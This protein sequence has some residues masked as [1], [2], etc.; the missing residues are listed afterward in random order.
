MYYLFVCHLTNFI[1]QDSGAARKPDLAQSEAPSAP[2]E[3][4]SVQ[5]KAMKNKPLSPYAM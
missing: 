1:Y 5:T 3:K 4:E 2:I